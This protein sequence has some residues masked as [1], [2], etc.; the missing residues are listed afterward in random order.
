MTTDL[1]D[2]DFC[3]IIG[4]HAHMHAHTH[5]YCKQDIKVSYLNV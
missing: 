2:L 4:I 1:S 5:I 3:M